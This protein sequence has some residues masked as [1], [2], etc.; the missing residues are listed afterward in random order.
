VSTVKPTKNGALEWSF[1][2]VSQMLLA[3]ERADVAA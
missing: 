2:Q 1:A 3:G